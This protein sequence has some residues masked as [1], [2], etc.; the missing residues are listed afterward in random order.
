MVNSVIEL[1]ELI[2]WLISEKVK[3]LKIGDIHVELSDYALLEGFTDAAT[4]AAETAPETKPSQQ[5]WTEQ[6]ASLSKEEE[7]ELFWSTR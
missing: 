4:E 5:T 3:S 7:E 6:P 2:I 1:Q